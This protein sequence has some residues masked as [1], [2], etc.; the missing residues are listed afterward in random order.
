MQFHKVK[1]VLR[2]KMPP[3]KI[4]VDIEVIDSLGMKV[5]VEKVDLLR[6][7]P[8]I[9]LAGEMQYPELLIEE[10]S[11][12]GTSFRREHGG[13]KVEFSENISAEAKDA[14]DRIYRFRIDNNCLNPTKWELNMVAE[15]YSDFSERLEG[16]VYI[17]QNR[18]VAHSWFYMHNDLYQALMFEKNPGLEIDPRLALDYD[19]LSDRA[20][21]V[22][23]DFDQLRNCGSEVASELLEIG[24]KN[25]RALKALV[26]DQFY[27][28]DFGLFENKDSFN[29]YKDLLEHPV[30]LLAFI[31][32]GFY[33][34]GHVK[35]FNYGFSKNWKN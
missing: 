33:S 35:S 11:R 18:L 28:W 24:Y 8:R 29:T 23:I 19:K 31:D 7:V 14:A 15:D 6:L 32:R 22:I 13:Y 17:N 26:S 25:E 16:A 30:R 34:P 1:M 27:K 4:L 2:D 5:R 20:A 9:D 10:Y 12:F 3:G 21:E